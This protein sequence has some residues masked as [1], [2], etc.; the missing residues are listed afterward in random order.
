MA[1]KSNHREAIPRTA[2]Q[3]LAV[4]DC[5]V[6]GLFMPQISQWV[7]EGE[8]HYT[9]VGCPRR[10]CQIAAKTRSIDGPAFDPC[11]RKD[12]ICDE[13]C[14]RYWLFLHEHS[15]LSILGRAFKEVV[16]RLERR[17]VKDARSARLLGCLKAMIES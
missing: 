3:R 7:D 13:S 12:E 17:A 2:E 15:E 4:N 11:H 5:P 8:E 6:H 1:T 14:L 16:T 10:D 9:W